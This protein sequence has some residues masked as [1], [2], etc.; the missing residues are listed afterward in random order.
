V[1]ITG[2]SG[3]LGRAIIKVFANDK[4]WTTLGLFLTKEPPSPSPS[5]I[6][7][8]CDLT[9]AE[10]VKTLVLEFKP[11]VLIHCAA[12]RRIED[13][14]KEPE[15]T[16]LLNVK[17]TENLAKL[18]SDNGCW[19]LYIS[20]DYIF[21]GKK[22]PYATNAETHPLNAYG[23]SKLDGETA[24][25][26]N[27][28]DAGVLRVPMLFGSVLNLDESAVTQVAKLVF[29]GKSTEMDDLQIRFPTHTEDVAAVCKGLAERK[30]E[31][32]G[33][34]GTWHCSGNEPFTK[35]GMALKIA[36]VCGV[37]ASHL[38][39]KK[40]E[41]PTR[42]LNSQLNCIALEVM[43]LSKRTPFADAIRRVLEPWKPS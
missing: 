41:D 28:P 16:N 21:D 42:P 3:L 33:L 7:K 19:L 38:K 17:V 43:G 12:M 2:A 15:K 27:Q 8:K 40:V 36:E 30:M 22:P 34:Y 39:P 4:N 5:T 20:T 29:E 11:D 23:K 1:L 35:Y 26:K 9:D 18:C 6:L 24:L 32:C 10:A 14:E 31:H 13:C 37:S 25:W